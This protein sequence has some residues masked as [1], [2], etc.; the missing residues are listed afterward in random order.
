MCF[1]EYRRRT[2]HVK[3]TVGLEYAM[4][5]LWLNPS[6]L[7]LGLYSL[8]GVN[9]TVIKVPERVKN[10]YGNIVKVIA[11]SRTAFAG[12]DNITDIILP[13]SVDRFPQSAFENCTGLRSIT[14]PKLT[15]PIPENT[16]A[17]CTALENVYY[18]GSAD[19]WKNMRVGS[20]NEALFSANI[21][22]DCG[23]GGMCGNDLAAKDVTEKI[24]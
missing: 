6:L 9:D 13:P 8:G 2:E 15:R 12:K 22:F 3:C 24:I 1:D 19:D 14:L 23:V 17:G 18:G 10:R 16:F 4:A 7:P 11:V 20:G 5:V 21:H